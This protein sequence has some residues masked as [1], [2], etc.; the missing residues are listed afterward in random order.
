MKSF[1]RLKLRGPSAAARSALPPTAIETSSRL[2]AELL[3]AWVILVTVVSLAIWLALSQLA[4][5]AARITDEDHERASARASAEALTAL[6]RQR[7]NVIASTAR[8]VQ[9]QATQEAR[10]QTFSLVAPGLDTAFSALF[11]VDPEGRG[12]VRLDEQG[13][14]LAPPHASVLDRPYFQEMLRTRKPVMSPPVVG[15]DSGRTAIVMAQPVLDGQR[16]VAVVAGV[17]RLESGDL[18]RL[19]GDRVAGAVRVITDAQGHILSHEA[20]LAL[21]GLPLSREPRFAAAYDDWV[22]QGRP[23]DM[24]GFSFVADGQV[25][26]GIPVADTPWIVWQS[27]PAA[28]LSGA[29][30]DGLQHTLILSLGALWLATLI[31]S[32][33]TVWRLI[34]LGRLVRRT[35]RLVGPSADPEPAA[36]WPR[37]G[38]ELGQLSGLLR[39]FAV[40]Q[41]GLAHANAEMQT[42]LKAVLA[43]APVGVA[44]VREGI[45]ELASAE[46]CRLFGNDAPQMLGRPARELFEDADGFVRFQQAA[47]GAAALGVPYGGDWRLR[48]SDGLGFWANLRSRPVD[49]ED[50]GLGEIWTLADVTEQKLVRQR[51][52]WQSRHDPLTGAANRTFFDQR[53]ARVLGNRELFSPAAL[54]FI[55]LDHFKPINDTAG[56]LAGDEVLKLVVQAIAAQSRSGDL[57]VRLGGD[58]FALLLE[59]CSGT[60]ALAVAQRIRV[61]VQEIGVPWEGTDLRVGASIGVAELTPDIRTAQDWVAAADAACYAA[62]TSGRNRVQVSPAKVK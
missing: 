9:A 41:S 15:R 59:Q 20:G 40:E 17:L 23:H 1:P 52:E 22:A 16:V 55:D 53:I 62:K 38:G 45:V 31:G 3:T 5:T 51:L 2:R 61:A 48:R 21:V 57:V 47:T 50:L 11:L 33:W 32:A 27:R 37:G 8:L 14:Q 39:Q 46:C 28:S 44:F 4:V 29:L 25:I 49:W 54:I 6:Q 35:Q 42:R 43:A 60:A 58:E 13:L 34:P 36:D 19:P 24:V 10:I 18:G 12:L 7:R 30:Q 56:H 26:A